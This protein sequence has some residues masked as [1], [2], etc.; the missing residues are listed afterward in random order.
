MDPQTAQTLIALT[1]ALPADRH[2]RTGQ[3]P[4]WHGDLGVCRLRLQLRD[5]ARTLA[6]SGDL[7]QWT[8]LLRE[9]HAVVDQIAAER[10]EAARQRELAEAY[11]AD[12]DELLTVEG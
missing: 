10:I 8:P 4:L 3:I 7:E 2:P 6:A 9:A 5:C 1:V 12:R 11:A